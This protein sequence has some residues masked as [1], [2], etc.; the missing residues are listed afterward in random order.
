MNRIYD[1]IDEAVRRAINE[2][3]GGRMIQDKLE[4]LRQ[5]DCRY[6]H[7][8][9]PE[10]TYRLEKI[11]DT[12]KKL[13]SFIEIVVDEGIIFYNVKYTTNE[14][15]EKIK[16]VFPEFKLVPIKIGDNSKGSLKG[17]RN[18]TLGVRL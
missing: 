13:N 8:M 2:E 11:D 5:M 6:N 3:I 10:S 1:I 9:S 7:Y 15:I 12:G 4:Q 16:Q 14:D 17:V 18:R